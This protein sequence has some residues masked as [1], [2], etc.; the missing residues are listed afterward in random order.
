ML[1]GRFFLLKF[2]KSKLYYECFYIKIF[3]K[4]VYSKLMHIFYLLKKIFGKIIYFF[5][6]IL[7]DDIKSRKIFDLSL[8]SN[9]FGNMNQQI[10]TTRL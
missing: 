7:A 1:K 6:K 8:I 10:L 2:C 4:F 3:L 9:N 5:L